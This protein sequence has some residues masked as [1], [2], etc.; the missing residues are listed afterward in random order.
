MISGLSPIGGWNASPSHPPRFDPAG[1][2]AAAREVRRPVH[3]VRDGV[4]GPVGV[5]WAGEV[6]GQVPLNGRAF[7][8]LAT[9]PALYPE[10]LGDRAFLAAH[11]V[12]F[13]YVAG[14]MA[15]GIATEELVV[16]MA[17]AGMLAFFGAAGLLPDR[18]ERAL[19]R[20]ERALGGSDASLSPP[21]YGANL[22][23]APN[24]PA[25]EDAICDLYLRRGLRRASASAFVDLTPAVVRFAA[26]GLTAGPDG[27]VRR[28]HRLFAK[29]SR[30]EVARR[31]LSPAPGPILDALLHDG[32]LTP[33]EARLAR[34]VPVAED[35][36][37][38]ADSGGH[39]DGQ[40]L[41]AVF[42]VL[43]ALRDRIVE[44]EGYAVAP[45][46]GAAGG[47]GTPASVA[48]AFGLGAA[49]VLTGSINQAAV[50]S[51]LS[52]EGRR[53]LAEAA[54]DDVCM[55]P[56]ADMF[57][58][59]VQVQVLRRGT[60]FAPRARRLYELYVAHEGLDDLPPEARAK[61]E[62]DVFQLPL[63]EVWA[64]TEAYF[65]SRDPGEID[66]AARDPRH[67]MAL[68]FRW[69]LGLSSR[70]AIEGTPERRLDYQ[71]WCGPA[72]GAFNAWTQGSFLASPERRGVVQ[73]ALN[74]LEGA[75]VLTRAHQLRTYGAPVP[76]DAF[77]FVPRPLETAP[78]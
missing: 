38:E 68:V 56:A 11:G 21:P 32:R 40:A 55:A 5:A 22:I 2:T 77:R 78:R 37:V 14:A 1:L 73:I 28:R 35:V 61:L 54:T 67:R 60:M 26:A 36:T 58:Q 23:H 29:V 31:F 65:R 33:E 17:Q 3:L 76:A 4:A 34:R 20:I 12:R 13:P 74:L 66:R 41:G 27:R 49:Y 8:L 10:W 47:L 39:T 18:V 45:R 48:A 6:T 64:R 52:A 57:E 19:E 43:Q 62:T 24:E 71:I 75:A 72:M 51:G 46:L 42:P 25:L 63:A 59:G 16:A 15:N 69:Y 70:W 9:L 7:P 30:V 44:E 50:E 53:L